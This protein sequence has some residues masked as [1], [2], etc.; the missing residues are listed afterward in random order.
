MVV[1]GVGCGGRQA[2]SRGH[3]H[4]DVVADPVQLLE[5]V[6]LD[7]GR[8]ELARLET[9]GVDQELLLDGFEG[10]VE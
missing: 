10:V 7:R 1:P 9:D 4:G 8:L 3:A 2:Q 6:L 5:D